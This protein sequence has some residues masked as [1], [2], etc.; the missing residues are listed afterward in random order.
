LGYAPLLFPDYPVTE[1]VHSNLTELPLFSGK[2]QDVVTGEIK[3]LHSSEKNC[4]H[5]EDTKSFVVRVGNTKVLTGR[6]SS[7][8]A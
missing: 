6:L 3:D 8:I 4:L 7:S 2:T 5:P 1:S